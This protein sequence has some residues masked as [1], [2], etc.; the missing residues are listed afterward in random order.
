MSEGNK[1][2]TK[3]YLAKIRVVSFYDKFTAAKTLLFCWYER[4]LNSTNSL[5]HPSFELYAGMIIGSGGLGEDCP[6]DVHKAIEKKY[7]PKP[8]LK[9]GSSYWDH[10]YYKQVCNSLKHRKPGGKIK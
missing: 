1:E 2:H 5:K 7:L 8:G 4:S 9:P 6:P 10:V 3:F